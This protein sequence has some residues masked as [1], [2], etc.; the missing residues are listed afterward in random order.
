MGYPRYL[1][2]K[3]LGRKLNEDD[4]V[5]HKDGNPLNN[6]LDN[7]EIISKSQHTI[8][9]N[10]RYAGDIEVVCAYCK[11]IFVLTIAQQKKRKQNAKNGSPGPFCSKSC[12]SKFSA[13][14]RGL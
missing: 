7:L 14:I 5:H 12:A 3:H 10:R 9:H 11:K 13:M 1:I 8:E 6:E 4:D 2:E